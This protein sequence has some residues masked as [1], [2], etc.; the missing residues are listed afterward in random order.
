[1]TLGQA[2]L[3]G[4]QSRGLVR[5]LDAGEVL[6]TRGD[7]PDGMYVL[8][9][10]RCSATGDGEE[11]HFIEPG[12]LF[13]ELAPL[14]GGRRTATVAATEASE[15]LR[16]TAEE[17]RES[18]L[19]REVVWSWLEDV[20]RRGR[21]I[22]EQQEGLLEETATRRAVQRMRMP[23][24]DLIRQ[25]ALR[26]LP[27]GLE[28]YIEGGA[29]DELTLRA[30]EEAWHALELAPHVLTGVR[31]RDPSVEVLGRRRPHPLIV[32][33]TGFQRLIHPDAEVASARG[34]RAAG[35]V[36][37]LSTFATT[38]AKELATKLP[39]L[40]WWFQLYWFTDRDLNW[41][42]VDNAV[43]AGAKAIVLTVDLATLGSRER[44][45]HSGFSL[46]GSMVVPNVAETGRHPTAKLAPVWAMLDPGICWQ[47]LEELVQRA[48]VP[49]I[50]KGLARGDDARRAADLGAAAVVVSNHGGRQ[51]DTAVATATALPEV[52]DAVD[53]RVDVLVDGGIRRGTD[54]VKALALGARAVLIGRPPLWGLA[55]GG[56]DGV[57]Q[58]IELLAN[59]FDNALALLGATSAGDLDRSLLR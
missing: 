44:D 21:D 31:E 18:D 49:V 33:P 35:A 2:T 8:L 58:V 52:V 55:A 19:P 1:M 28:G 29:G 51:L 57:Q 46:R 4:L 40:D 22:K 9:S 10:G 7:A 39:G 3:A 5:R 24:V 12:E 34:A 13:G 45:H 54:I 50:V 53:G 14:G 15:V 59:E 17:I 47:D 30:N 11:Q 48:A 43:A 20:A 25:I 41:A 23:S 36:F 16:I 56:A 26:Q 27:E 38:S 37:C 32:G 6:F 42:L